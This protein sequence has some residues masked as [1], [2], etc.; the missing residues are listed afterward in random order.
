MGTENPPYPKIMHGVKGHLS[1]REAVFLKNTPARLG[2]GLYGE[3]GTWRGRSAVVTAAGMVDDNVDAHLITV[4]A[5]D[6]PTPHHRGG[7]YRADEFDNV[8]QDM[9]D[10]GVGDHITMVK[11][12]TVPTAELYKDKE[13]VFVFIDADHS[14]EGAKAD[15]E[16]WSPLVKSGGEVAFHDSGLESVGQVLD[17]IPWETYTVDSI[18]VKVKP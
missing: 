17:E 13:F 4:D 10:R 9:V 2:P 6:L 15:F 7:T 16:A 8:R 14:Y 5:W 11:G 1:R 12:L 18:T 3:L